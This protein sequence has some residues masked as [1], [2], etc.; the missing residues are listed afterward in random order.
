MDVELDPD[1]GRR[2]GAMGRLAL[3]TAIRPGNGDFC[4]ARTLDV[5]ALSHQAGLDALDVPLPG[6]DDLADS[7]MEALDLLPDVVKNYL[8]GPPPALIELGW[9]TA[10][11]GLVDL[12]AFVRR[13]TEALLGDI[14]VHEVAAQ[15]LRDLEAPFADAHI[16]EELLSRTGREMAER[17]GDSGPKLITPEVLVVTS[18]V[19]GLLDT[20]ASFDSDGRLAV[21]VSYRSSLEPPRLFARVVAPARDRLLAVEP[22]SAVSPEEGSRRLI[23]RFDLGGEQPGVV[24]VL[25]DPDQPVV[26]LGSAR[27]LNASARMME[28]YR[29][30]QQR[31]GGQGDRSSAASGARD[32]ATAVAPRTSSTPRWIPWNESSP[33]PVQS[34]WRVYCLCRSI[35]FR[36]MVSPQFSVNWRTRSST[37][38]RTFPTRFAELHW[39]RT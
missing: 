14:D 10:R 13:S 18:S 7:A 3:A 24:E 36:A 12:I 28:A 15:L 38:L 31:S 8:L 22:M 30:L 20:Q 19:R 1:G 9:L 6:H 26:G 39:L 17:L 35:L 16:P 21:S 27:S 37:L 25:L 33:T 34:I 2:R 4:P 32:E 11:Q 5:A 29:Q 23:A